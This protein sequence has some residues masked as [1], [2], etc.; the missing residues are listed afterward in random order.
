MYLL[1]KFAYE[2]KCF[3][4]FVKFFLLILLHFIVHGKNCRVSRRS[5]HKIQIFKLLKVAVVVTMIKIALN[6][7]MINAILSN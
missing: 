1:I 5:N 3:I 4:Y 6:V 7:Q 2:I